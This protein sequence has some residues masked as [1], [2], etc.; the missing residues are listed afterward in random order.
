MLV[1]SPGGGHKA[2]NQPITAVQSLATATG[3][4]II[5]EYQQEPVRLLGDR[6]VPYFAG[7]ARNE[8]VS[9]ELL[10]APTWNLRPKEHSRRYG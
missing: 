3:S 7:N 1:D 6:N 4:E 2:H 5:S 8:D 10:G 9:L